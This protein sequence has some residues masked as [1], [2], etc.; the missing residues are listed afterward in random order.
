MA[1][2]SFKPGDTV[3]N[4]KVSIYLVR[5]STTPGEWIVRQFMDGP[6]PWKNRKPPEEQTMTE[7][8]LLEIAADAAV[9]NM[10][11]VS[12]TASMRRKPVRKPMNEIRRAQFRLVHRRAQLMGATN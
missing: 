4:R 1:E 3:R 5:K 8:C 11:R 2:S 12:D 9:R 6:G 10:T 7:K